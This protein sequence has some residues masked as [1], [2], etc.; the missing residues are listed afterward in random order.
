MQNR[1]AGDIGD[2]GKF[3]LLK[4][5]KSENIRLGVNWYLVLKEEENKDGEKTEYLENSKYVKTDKLLASQLSKIVNSENR[6]IKLIEESNVL[7]EGTIYYSEEVKQGKELREN[8]FK[9]SLSILK[10]ADLIFLDPDNGMEVKSCPSKGRKKSIKYVYCDE[11]EEYYKNGQSILIYQHATRKKLEEHR[12]EWAERFIKNLKLN[13]DQ[14]VSIKGNSRYYILI[15][16]QKH[17]NTLS[18]SIKEL[19]NSHIAPEILRIFK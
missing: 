13:K 9:Q 17:K 4:R 19:E 2:F 12:N 10:N 16:Q 18:K 6:G 1:Y 5:L 8:W 7:P 11:V 14:L 15:M 3:L